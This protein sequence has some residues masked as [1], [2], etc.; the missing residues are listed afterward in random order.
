MKPRDITFIIIVVFVVGGLYFL[1]SRARTPSPMPANPAHQNAKTREQCLACH[2]PEK[3]AEL[4]KT[5]KHPGKW[6][7][8]K[9]N[10]LQ[11]HHTFSTEG[12]RAGPGNEQPQPINQQPR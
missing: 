4:E 8:V 2:L 7:D 3:L 11:C 12:S 9:V 5:H 1:S 6:R 10:C